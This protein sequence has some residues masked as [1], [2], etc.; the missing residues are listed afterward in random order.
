ML[1]STN[2]I[3]VNRMS[4]ASARRQLVT[5]GFLNTDFKSAPDPSNPDN[6]LLPV[7]PTYPN[8]S[9]SHSMP[10]KCFSAKQVLSYTLPDKSLLSFFHHSFDIIGSICI[11]EL[12]DQL[13]P[14]SHLVGQATLAVNHNLSSV[15][16]KASSRSGIFRRNQLSLAAG[17]ESTVTK[18]TEN[19]I[20]FH[21]DLSTCYFSP[22]SHTERLRISSLVQSHERVL[23]PLPALGAFR[24]ILVNLKVPRHME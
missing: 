1:V 20:T 13:I 10:L 7:N 23:V 4:F 19:G 9:E 16:F 22:R 11:I 24:S 21:I 6:L 12:H 5:A 18:F 2:T 3:S 8:H 17:K 14:Y 15:F